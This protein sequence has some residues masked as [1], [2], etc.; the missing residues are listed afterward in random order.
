MFTFDSI[1]GLLSNMGI[2]LVAALVAY[3]VSEIAKSL[4]KGEGWKNFIPF[5]VY[6][7]AFIVYLVIALTR[8]FAMPIP[9]ALL[10]ALLFLI[11]ESSA[12]VIIKGVSKLVKAIVDHFKG[13][14]GK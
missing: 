9:T 12:F 7:L 14:V 1:M 10:N 8:G 3:G 5:I 4:I 13:K 2:M 6:A 11:L